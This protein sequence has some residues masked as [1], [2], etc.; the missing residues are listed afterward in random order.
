MGSRS[1]VSY[2]TVS[3]GETLG[4]WNEGQ[5]ALFQPCGG[6]RL[7]K[8]ADGCEWMEEEYWLGRIY[9]DCFYL[10]YP[11]PIPLFLAIQ[12]IEDSERIAARHMEFVEIEQD[13]FRLID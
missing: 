13:E 4:A 12:Y 8:A 3:E 7:P 10:E 9:S 11:W 5:W 6:P 1:T 2:I